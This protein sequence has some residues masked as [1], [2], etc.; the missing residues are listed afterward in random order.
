[1]VEVVQER[2]M[3][4]KYR[5]AP[6][7]PFCRWADCGLA[8]CKNPQKVSDWDGF[9]PISPNT[10]SCTLSGLLIFILASLPDLHTEARCGTGQ[11]AEGGGNASPLSCPILSCPTWSTPGAPLGTCLRSA[12]PWPLRSQSPCSGEEAPGPHP[13]SSPSGLSTWCVETSPAQTCFCPKRGFFSRDLCFHLFHAGKRKKALLTHWCPSGCGSCMGD[14]SWSV[15][16]S[17]K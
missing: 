7:L 2:R 8:I 11:G 14:L 9:E 5:S 15:W 10:L 1:M 12:A 16:P 13:H 6:I 17:V 4:E 3:V